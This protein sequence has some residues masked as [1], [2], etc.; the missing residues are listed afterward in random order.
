MRASYPAVATAIVLGAMVAGAQETNRT[1]ELAGREAEL[2]AAAL[3]RENGQLREELSRL[4]R[5][6]G[7]MTMELAQA[8]AGLDAAGRGS[9]TNAID[10]T[11]WQVVEINHELGLVVVDAGRPSGLQKS[12]LMYVMRDR[13]MVARARA[14]DVRER[15]T[16]ARIEEILVA[17]GPKRG[18]RVVRGEVPR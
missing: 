13:T 2:V 15:I 16:G 6:I 10:T 7:Q 9:T 11:G 14:V 12:D 1:A 17:G 5:E 3:I 4:K 18:D 8:K